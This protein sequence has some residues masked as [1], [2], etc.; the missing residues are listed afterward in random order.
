MG[1]G[2]VPVYYKLLFPAIALAVIGVIA[3]FL[4]DYLN[5]P[6][7]KCALSGGKWVEFEN[8]CADSC[9]LKRSDKNL[10]CPQVKTMGC[11]C[12]KGMCWERSPSNPAGECVPIWR[13]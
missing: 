12:P 11:D 8:G 10:N 1:R 5:G 3:F 6:G 13:E 7:G 9:V 2:I 4:M